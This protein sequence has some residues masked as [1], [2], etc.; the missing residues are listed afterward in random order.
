[1]TMM[2]TSNLENIPVNKKASE[3]FMELILQVAVGIVIGG[4]VLVWVLANFDTVL[5]FAKVAISLLVILFIIILLAA[6]VLA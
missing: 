2:E 6:K 3:G 4:V 1:M 5:E